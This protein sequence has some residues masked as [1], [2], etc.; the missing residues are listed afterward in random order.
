M[1][2]GRARPEK[3][4]GHWWEVVDLLV[5]WRKRNE[6]QNDDRIKAGVDGYVKQLYTHTRA[7]THSLTWVVQEGWCGS[8]SVAA[9][10]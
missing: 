2:R 1:S 4:R 9:A 3:E 7:N 5:V 6:S 8:C 10:G